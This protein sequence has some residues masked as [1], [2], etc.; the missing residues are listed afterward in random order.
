MTD[1]IRTIGKR[2]RR[3]V[4]LILNEKLTNGRPHNATDERLSWFY[5]D[6]LMTKQDNVKD[7]LKDRRTDGQMNGQT[8]EDV[9]I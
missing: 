5:D 2:N 7:G 4:F 9:L 8:D 1:D 3:I 6:V